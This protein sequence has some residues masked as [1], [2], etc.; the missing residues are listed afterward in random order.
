MR[1]AC[2]PLCACCPARQ[3]VGASLTRTLGCTQKPLAPGRRR[4]C[5]KALNDPVSSFKRRA[6]ARRLSAAIHSHTATQKIEFMRG[7]VSG[8]V[9]P[10]R[11]NRPPSENFA[12]RRD[13][14]AKAGEHGK[15][16]HTWGAHRRRGVPRMPLFTCCASVR[17]VHMKPHPIY[18]GLPVQPNPSFKLSPNG[19]SRRPSC[20]G[21]AAHCAHAVQRAKPSVPA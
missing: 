4:G 13:L 9:P 19:L 3:A 10:A 8:T 16:T 14:P 5:S 17:M 11:L 20:A 1:W 18:C 7:Q 21:P 15:Q 12:A 6:G 2:G